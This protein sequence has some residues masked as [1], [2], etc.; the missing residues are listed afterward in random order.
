[1]LYVSE[2][3]TQIHPALSLI[4]YKV[5]RSEGTHTEEVDSKG[6]EPDEHVPVITLV[7][8]PENTVIM[9]AALSDKLIKKKNT[10]N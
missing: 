6:S 3:D 8:C 2:K 7:P 4:K 5:L 9:F 1:M 10:I